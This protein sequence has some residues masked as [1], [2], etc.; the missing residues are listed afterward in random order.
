M[1]HRINGWGIRNLRWH[2]FFLGAGFLLLEAQIISKMALL[3][4]TTWV[5]NSIVI[6][7][8]LLLILCANVVVQQRER[9]PYWL[10]YTGMFGS[11]G[12]AWLVPLD[13]LFFHSL[14]VRATVAT[15][16]LCLPVFFAGII[17]I[18]SFAQA[19]FSG[20]ALGANL[21]GALMGGLLESLS[22]WM[23]LKALLLIAALLYVASALTLRSE[24][25]A[26]V[27]VIER[28]GELMDV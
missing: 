4:G 21:F 25:T 10:A 15:P 6:S 17:F 9:I 11:F 22:F 14:I 23:G 26:P 19:G 5:V 7:A 1:V 2:F 16:V 18:R 28:E 27:D 12:L 13:R 20:K 8:L 3:F 24:L